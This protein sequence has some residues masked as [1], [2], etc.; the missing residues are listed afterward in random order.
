MAKQWKVQCKDCGK[1][2][3]YSDSSY[4]EG[5]ERGLSR[6][7]RCPDCRKKHNRQTGAM[8][9]AYF[10]LKPRSSADTSSVRSGQ[11]GAVSHEKRS[12]EIYE[13]PSSYDP[14]KFG[15]TD[16]DVRAIFD[17][18]GTP[19]HQVVVVEGP[20]GSGKSTVLP[21]KLI[22]PPEGLPADQ[23]TRHGQVVVT[24]PRIQATRNIPAYV[25][26]TLYGSSLGSGFDI[27]FRYSN[28]PCS[29]WRN[30]LVY[31]TDGTLINWIVSGQIANLSVIM[32][33][34][35][36]ER[37][38]NIDLILGLLKRLLPRYPHLKLIIASAT[39]DADLFIDYFG[40]ERTG[41]V[42]FQGMQKHVVKEFYRFAGTTPEIGEDEYSY[43]G[44]SPLPYDDMSK[45]RRIAPQE[46]AGVVVWLLKEIA[47]D[48]KQPGDILAFLQGE[49]PIQEA[50][51]HIRQAVQE[52]TRL[53]NVYV[54][55]LYTTLPQE[56]QNK[57]LL[58]KPDPSQRRVVITTNVAETSLTVED[59]IYVVDSGLINEAQWDPKSQTKQVVPVLQSRAGC[60]QRWGR[61]GRITD[62]EAYCLYTKEQ[63]HTLFPAYTIP[64]IQRSPLE[65]IVLTAKAAGIDDI[66][67]FDWIQKPPLEELRRAP[68]VLM[69]KGALDLQG[70]ITE[71]GLELQAFAEEPSLAN[72]MVVADRYCCA[73]EMATLLPM[74]KLGG[75][76]HL[77]RWE[78][79]WDAPTRRQVRRLQESLMKSCQDDIEYCL[80]MYVA[81]SETAYD[82]QPLDPDWS[83]RE[84]WSRRIPRLPD[85]AQELLQPASLHKFAAAVEAAAS[86]Y[87]LEQI[88][89]A[90]GLTEVAESWLADASDAMRQAS[91]EAWARAFFV[92]HSVF[93]NK[94]EPERRKL[95]EDLSGHKKDDIVRPVDF[96][97][98][99]RLRI[100]LAYCLPERI[101]EMSHR[102]PAE[103][104][105]DGSSGV[106]VYRM[107]GIGLTEEAAAIQASMSVMVNSDSVLYSR[108]VEVFVGCKQQVVTHR[109][110]P[111]QPP[112]PVIHSSIL[113]L[114]DPAWLVW[115]ERSGHSHI[116][117][118]RF[119]AENTRAIS[120]ELLAGDVYDRAFTDLAFPVGSRYICQVM[121]VQGETAD[122]ILRER[123]REVPRIPEVF[124]KEEPETLDSDTDT[125]EESIGASD[126]PDTVLIGM[127]APVVDPE[128][129]TRPTWVDLADDS[130]EIAEAEMT[131]LQLQALPI[132]EIPESRAVPIASPSAGAYT[133]RYC[134][135][136][137]G[138][139]ITEY[140]IVLAEV[141]DFDFSEA[142]TPTVVLSPVPEREPMEAFLEQYSEPGATVELIATG[143]EARPGDRK[144]ALVA[145]EPT[146][147]L[148]LLLETE[149]LSFNGRGFIAREIPVG[150]RI[151]ALLEDVDKERSRIQLNCLPFVEDHLNSVLRR[152]QTRDSFF[153]ANGTVKETNGGRAWFVLDWS[154]PQRG[155]IHCISVA[156]RGLYQSADDFKLGEDSQLRLELQKSAVFVKLAEL[157]DEVM[158]VID[159]QGLFDRL[160]WQSGNLQFNGR[161]TY[162]H[163]VQLKAASSDPRYHEA[164]DKLYR[165]SNG[166]Y[167]TVKD[168]TWTDRVPAVGTRVADAKVVGIVDFGLFVEL[169]SGIRGLVYRSE[170]SWDTSM[171]PED[172]AEDGDLVDVIVTS[173]DPG[174]QEIRLTMKMPEDAPDYARFRVT[175]RCRGTV[176]NVES[177]GA[178]VE[179]APSVTGLVHKSE[180]WG[181]VADAREVIRAGEKVTVE[182]ISVDLEQRKIGLSLKLPEYDPLRK[183]S[184]HEIVEGR[185]T[186]IADY[187]A[188]V[189]VE[190]GI[191]GLVHKSEISNSSFF[192][193]RD[194]ICRFLQVGQQV[195][196]RILGIDTEKRRLSLS[197]KQAR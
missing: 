19:E 3:G 26:K 51:S 101:C 112:E 177:Y 136:T 191:S 110:A 56:E 82:N 150:A 103:A 166:F 80:K 138:S 13:L 161:M 164:L 173:V 83:F 2:F 135:Q 125:E 183:Y 65:Q 139:P 90:F 40:R 119:I 54:C 171:Q 179:I 186:N 53:A 17:W 180:M 124:S 74:I 168:P 46:V 50:V 91:R 159:R 182:I 39:I 143:Y 45:L 148:E 48:K 144:V 158:R 31:V 130:Y 4:Q 162:D 107:R 24:Q 32:I 30:K 44:C 141:I 142:S 188:F 170:I 121:T 29:D 165:F 113:S 61:A 14:S 34:E 68:Q 128:E 157:P 132:K 105:S 149:Q 20:T 100:I 92:N 155:F 126:L 96:S 38:L 79:D 21:F 98:I 197:I 196:V 72:L 151:Q 66:E 131:E 154:E 117:L 129:E 10:P 78:K 76:R 145:K 16:D 194:D 62:G 146:S 120:G 94:I 134:L 118:A 172:I 1:E 108:P 18:L 152:K 42:K 12:H 106:P 163:C 57:A 25:A 174:K 35:A 27:G 60:K 114:V 49:K 115:M 63:F 97:L 87:E 88:A 64:Q 160:S 137:N 58:P 47:A 111:D 89:T 41:H 81:W 189:E 6:P 195:H 102:L 169:P 5:A 55:P 28:N 95:L 122:V 33:D 184:P 69:K 133:R 93:K 178:F 8:G 127:D 36:H 22:S 99:D 7:E 67:N 23:F 176:T 140:S 190:P 167:A 181:S 9:L 73:V 193:G 109:V 86:A 123:V 192:R 84:V 77:V 85:A 175:D 43:E 59:I 156:G 52:D 75:L 153:T 37:S 116:E 15:I 185:V 104:T 147:G 11:L 70:D 187:G 71:H